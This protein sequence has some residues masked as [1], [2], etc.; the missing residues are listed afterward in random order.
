MLGTLTR[1]WWKRLHISNPMSPYDVRSP[2]PYPWLRVDIDFFAYGGTSYL[3]AVDTYSTLRLRGFKTP[4]LRLSSECHPPGSQGM[5]YRQSLAQTVAHNF[6]RASSSF[7]ISTTW[8]QVQIVKQI[9]KKC[10]EAGVD[11]YLVGSLDYRSCPLAGERSPGQLLYG[12]KLRTQLPDFSSRP[13]VLCAK[14]EKTRSLEHRWCFWGDDVVCLREKG[15]WL[16]KVRVTEYVGPCSYSVQI[17]HT[18]IYRGNH[19]HLLKTAET[20]S[21]LGDDVGAAASKCARTASTWWISG[22]QC[23]STDWDTITSQNSKS[24]IPAMSTSL[25]WNI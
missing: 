2:P 5:A 20:F 21:S 19:C 25:W 17:E 16:K 12:R 10:D 6:C 23:C 13:G 18:N 4:P 9:F 24:Q 22:G 1:S 11:V 8:H 15:S 3:M 7:S 14:S